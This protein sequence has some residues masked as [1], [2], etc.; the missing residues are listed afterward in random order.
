[1][2]SHY[3]TAGFT[4]VELMVVVLIVGILAAIALPSYDRYVTKARRGDGTE[5]LL[6]AAQAFE[7]YRGRAATY[8]ESLDLVNL[9]TNSPEG[10]YGNLTILEPT[11]ACPISSCYVIQIDAQNLQAKD[12]IKAFRLSSTGVEQRLED[13]AWQTNWR[14]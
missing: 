5:T 11:A 8:P 3:K 2:I 14:E 1:M 7:V 12:D 6:A 10:Y 9:G 4:L 13:S